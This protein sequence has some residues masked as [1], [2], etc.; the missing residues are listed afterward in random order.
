MTEAGQERVR[1]FVWC[2]VAYIVAIGVGLAVGWYTWSQGPLWAVIW[3]DVAGTVVIFVFSVLFRNSS[4]YDP[5]W[6][7]APLVIVVAWLLVPQSK[8]AVDVRRWMVVALVF[9]WG[10]RLT[11]NWARGWTGLDHEDW[12]YIN[13]QKTTGVFYWP[14]SFLGIHMFPT[15][16]VLLGCVPVYQAMVTGRAPLGVLDGAAFVVTLSAILIEGIA[17]QQLRAFALS[18]KKPEDIMDKG[19]WSVSRHPN[20][21]GELLFWWGLSLFGVA[22]VPFVWWTLSGGLAM[23]FLFVVISIPMLDKKML[24]KRPHYAEHM[25]RISG[26]VPWFPRKG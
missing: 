11:Y 23:T 13:I 3:G 25:K 12:R 5:Y 22:A 19:L 21:F 26:V 20:Y 9:L 6:S 2:V 4:F 18:D 24:G 16:L 14:V 8:G 17:D 7:I 10:V 1:G 15:V